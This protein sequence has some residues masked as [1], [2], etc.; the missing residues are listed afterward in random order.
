MDFLYIVGRFTGSVD[1]DPGPGTYLLNSTLYY[2]Y[3]G[4]I[5]KFD[6]DGNFQWVKHL[7]GRENKSVNSIDADSK[8]NLY[9]TGFFQKL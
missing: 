3:D 7:K 5:L 1:F 2:R 8:G 6:L 9:C 4:Y